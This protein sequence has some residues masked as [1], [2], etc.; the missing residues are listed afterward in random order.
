MVQIK[1]KRR[2]G[3][4]PVIVVTF[5]PTHCFCTWYLDCF[6]FYH[7]W[8]EKIDVFPSN[9]WMELKQ[10]AAVNL[11]VPNCVPRGFLKIDCGH[12]QG[13]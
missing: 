3:W 8:I 10:R 5:P 9:M 11:Q 12:L 7:H 13:A 4:S 6:H 1:C 2:D